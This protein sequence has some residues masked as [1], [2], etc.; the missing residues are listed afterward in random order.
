M[1]VCLIYSSF[2]SPFSLFLFIVLSFPL[3]PTSESGPH[4]RGVLKPRQGPRQ[5]S[6]TSDYPPQRHVHYDRL[7]KPAPGASLRH[8][9]FRDVQDVESSVMRS[10]SSLNPRMSVTSSVLGTS[11]VPSRRK[12]G[13]RGHRILCLDG[14]GVKVFVVVVVVVL[15]GDGGMLVWWY[16]FVSVGYMTI[17]MTFEL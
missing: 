9:R 14:G 2:Y 10:M 6:H 5:R 4:P 16:F 7:P 8:L 3:H 13:K 12:R 1:C 11:V 15:L 17:C